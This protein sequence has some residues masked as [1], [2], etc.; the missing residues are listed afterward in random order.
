MGAFMTKELKHLTATMRLSS[1]RGLCF[2]RSVAL[3]LDWPQA[4]VVIGHL[5]GARPDELAVDPTLSPT[6]LY[7]AWCETK[8]YVFSPSSIEA[9]GHLQAFERAD[10]YQTN[11][12]IEARTIR[13]PRI[14]ALAEEFGWRNHVLRGS[15]LKGDK[16]FAEPLLDEVGYE[17]GLSDQNGVVPLE[18]ATRRKET[19]A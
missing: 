4:A 12:V 6:P 9:I 16:A 17:W 8:D 7:H 15:P 5:P 13:R 1:E 18:Y 11:E 3:C 14:L 2:H 19:T 10:Y